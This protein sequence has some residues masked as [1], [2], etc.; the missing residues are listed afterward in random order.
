ME[1]AGPISTITIAALVLQFT[2]LRPKADD[3]R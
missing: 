2:V 1:K 3:V